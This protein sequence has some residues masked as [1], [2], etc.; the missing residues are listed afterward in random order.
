MLRHRAR[1]GRASLSVVSEPISPE[2]GRA[3]L[4]RFALVAERQKEER[5]R[6]TLEQRFDEL[7]KLMLSVDDFGWRA[8]LDDDGSVRARWA[9]LRQKLVEQPQAAPR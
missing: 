7:E 9:L 6:T 2:E 5:A 4:Q 8:A 1:L 3:Y